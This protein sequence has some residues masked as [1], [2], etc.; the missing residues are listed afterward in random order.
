MTT[1]LPPVPPAVIEF[2]KENNIENIKQD[3]VFNYKKEIFK[4][5]N[6]EAAYCG[7]SKNTPEFK[8]QKDYIYTSC[9]FVLIDNGKIRLANPKETE[10]LNRTII[11]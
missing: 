6:I 2:A 5:K 9:T 1:D 4:Y 11:L 3:T 10:E 7:Y 8:K